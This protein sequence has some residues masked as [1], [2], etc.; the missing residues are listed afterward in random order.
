MRQPFVRANQVIVDCLW[1]RQ[2]ETSTRNPITHFG[3]GLTLETSLLNPP[4]WPIYLILC[5]QILYFIQMALSFCGLTIMN[6]NY[7][8]NPEKKNFLIYLLIYL[9]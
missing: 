1:F 5:Q 3:E 9:L 7:S 6:V 2:I 4:L 8:P